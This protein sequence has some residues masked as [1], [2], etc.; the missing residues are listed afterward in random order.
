[1]T[2]YPKIHY[3]KTIKVYYLI[4]SAGQKFGDG[5]AKTVCFLWMTPPLSL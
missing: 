3:L 1:M 4:V 5:L 2:N